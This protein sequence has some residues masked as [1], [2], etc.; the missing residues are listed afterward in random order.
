[1]KGSLLVLGRFR[2]RELAAR[3]VDGV[4]EDVLIAPADDG[5][6]PAPEAIFRAVVGRPVKGLGGVFVDLPGGQTGFLRQTRGLAPGARVIVQV[7][8]VAEGGKAVPVTTRLLIKG[9]TVILTPEAPGLNISRAIR[10]PEARARLDALARAGMAGADETLGLIL[11]SASAEARDDEIA[12]ELAELR[13]LTERLLADTGGPAE[14]LL[15]APGP[16]D[17]AWRDWAHPL[18]DTVEQG[19]DAVAALGVDAMLDDLLR[20]R[21]PLPG[22][23]HMFIEPTRAL[24][25]VDVNTGGDTSPAAGLK[26]NLAAARDLPRQLRLRGLGGQIAVDFAPMPKR[27]RAVLEQCLRAA[28]RKDASETTLAGWTPLGNYE[29]QRKRDRASLRSLLGK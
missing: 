6:L 28:F 8:G 10:E 4:I 15:D 29:L 19:P 13:G 23:G 2:D 5:A 1:M 21:V 18:P 27:D 7:S 11:R 24:V 20:A 16:H 22:G 25:A 17:L 12:D 26:A 9:R 14:L 3:L